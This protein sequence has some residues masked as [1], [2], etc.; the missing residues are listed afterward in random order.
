[1]DDSCMLPANFYSRVIV[2]VIIGITN[3]VNLRRAVVL[4]LTIGTMARLFWIDK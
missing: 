4:P 1:M 2:P 3:L